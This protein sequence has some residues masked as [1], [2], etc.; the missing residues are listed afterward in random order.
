M[1]KKKK[2]E[3]EG[4]CAGDQKRRRGDL[5]EVDEKRGRDR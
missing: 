2:R 1:V 4:V 5:S 3:R